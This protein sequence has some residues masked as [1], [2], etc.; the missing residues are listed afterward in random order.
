MDEKL[1]YCVISFAVWSLANLRLVT[2]YSLIH[3]TD[4]C[5]LVYE[6]YYGQQ[7]LWGRWSA[8]ASSICCRPVIH[9][10]SPWETSVS[11]LFTTLWSQEKKNWLFFKNNG[12]VLEYHKFFLCSFRQ[13]LSD[14]LGIPGTVFL[15]KSCSVNWIWPEAS[16]CCLLHDFFKGLYLAITLLIILHIISAT[17][18]AVYFFYW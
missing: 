10:S 12:L 4:I 2:A 9:F 6:T 14:F 8:N 5:M 15:K 1:R 7:Q 11:I 16:D 3:K 13:F 18:S 17:D